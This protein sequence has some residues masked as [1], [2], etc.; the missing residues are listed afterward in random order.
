MAVP[1]L[2]SNSDI[3]ADNDNVGPSVSMGELLAGR[4]ANDGQVFK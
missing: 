4:Q 2:F 3:S 1:I